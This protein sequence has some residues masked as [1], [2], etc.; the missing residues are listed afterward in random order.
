MRIALILCVLLV[1]SCKRNDRELDNT[2][3]GC[4]DHLRSE[5]QLVE[6]FQLVDEAAKAESGLRSVISCATVTSDTVASPKTLE[7]DFGTG[8]ACPD[9]KMR[10]GKILA[11]LTGK[12]S[13]LGTI[14]SITTTDYTVAGVLI[15][16]GATLANTGTTTAN[17]P[18]FD[19]YCDSLKMLT[20]STN[21]L[22]T[23]SCQYAMVQTTGA[24][25]VDYA[26]D[27]FL[28]TGQAA[29]RNRKGNSYAA[30]IKT[31]IS[32]S[33]SCSWQYSG[34]A[35]VTPENLTKRTVDYGS[36]CD[37]KATCT[38]NFSKVEIEIE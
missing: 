6:I 38:V 3:Q 23:W 7:I 36:S 35:E 18:R 25:T 26:D 5:K 29:G 16:A 15:K 37:N 2:V 19:F 24:G 34:I 28:L 14:V 9:G 27:E 11:T 1:V 31:A 30:V 10:S 17:E 20:L 13:T 8:T 21:E 4:K 12:L 33:H 32:I 22:S